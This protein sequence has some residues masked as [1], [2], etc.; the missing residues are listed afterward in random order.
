MLGMHSRSFILLSVLAASLSSCQKDDK[1]SD[2]TPIVEPSSTDAQMVKK[3]RL[4]EVH[5]SGQMVAGENIK[6]RHTMEFRADGT[7]SQTLLKDGTVFTGTWKLK[8]KATVL[9]ISDHKKD[10]Q[11]YTVTLLT[12]KE[13][14][15]TRDDKKSNTT[16]EMRFTP[17]P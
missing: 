3:W 17:V 1:P 7:Y 13:L 12:D 4:D 10:Q 9:H 5:S 15:Y 11:D 8:Q 14:R 16:T 2:P 6:D